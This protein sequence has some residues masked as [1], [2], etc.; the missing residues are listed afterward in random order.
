MERLRAGPRYGYPRVRPRRLAV[1]AQLSRPLTVFAA[2]LSGMLM[3][4]YVRLDPLHAL[5]LS[6]MFASMQAAGQVVNQITDVEI[7]RIAKPYRPLPRGAVG[8]REAWA[9]AVVYIAVAVVSGSIF[10]GV[11][12]LVAAL[13]VLLAIYYSLEPVRAKKRAWVNVVWQAVARGLYPPVALSL[14]LYHDLDVF[15]VYFSLLAFM[16]VLAFQSTKDFPDMEADAKFGVRTLPVLYG[17]DGARRVMAGLGVLYSAAL[18]AM[19]ASGTIP[20]KFLAVLPLVPAILLTL[21]VE[22]P[23]ENNVA[24]NLFYAGLGLHY[25]L[26][27]A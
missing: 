8:T 24:W 22:A 2:W 10:G 6:V 23:T 7:D 19:V 1:Y 16:W 15:L 26:L 12:L 25:L 9:L 17:P 11:G 27:V 5:A 20:P 13:G 18:L 21:N 14:I 4:V 3:A